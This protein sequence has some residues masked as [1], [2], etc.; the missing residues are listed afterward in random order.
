LIDYCESQLKLK[1]TDPC[2]AYSIISL[3]GDDIHDD[4]YKL[5]AALTR[6]G[7]LVKFLNKQEKRA[8]GPETLTN[9][10]DYGLEIVESDR[11]WVNPDRLYLS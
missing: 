9:N 10:P 3:L 8:S 11:S 5:P 4:D 2:I 6:V 1:Y 7:F